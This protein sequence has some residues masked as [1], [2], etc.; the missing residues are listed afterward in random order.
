MITA[1]ERT[2]IEPRLTHSELPSTQSGTGRRDVWFV[3]IVSLTLLVFSSIPFVA[4]YLLARPDRQFM[5]LVYNVHDYAQYMSWARESRDG[6]LVENKLTSEPGPA[7]FFNLYWWSLGRATRLFGLTFIQADQ[8]FRV[9][10]GVAFVLVTWWFCGLAIADRTGRRVAFVLACFASGFGWLLVAL[11]PFVGELRAPLLVHNSLGNTFFSLM[12]TPH[13]I[14]A[15]ANVAASLGLVLQGYRRGCGRRMALA[16]LLALVLGLYHTYDL[17]LVYAVVGAFGS[18]MLLRDGLRPRRLLG[19]VAFYLISAPAPLFWVWLTVAHPEWR[20]V[21]DQFRNLGVFTPDPLGLLVLIGPTLALALV[22]Y[23]G[24]VPL[25]QR[26]DDELLLAAWLGVTLLVIYLPVNFQIMMLNGLQICLAIL[27][28]RALIDHV[29]PWVEQAPQLFGLRI[30]ERVSRARCSVRAIALTLLVLAVLPTNI[31]LLTW[32]ILDL[33]RNEYPYYLRRSDVSALEWLQQHASAT[34]VVLSS[35]E[36]GHFVAGSTGAHAFLA[37]GANTLN[38][39]EK[40]TL[41]ARF[42]G[43]GM[44][45][46]ERS[47]LLERHGVT[48][49]IQGPAEMRGRDGTDMARLLGSPEYIDGETRIWRVGQPGR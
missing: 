9:I 41:V 16:G 31:Y 30:P 5:G 13:H 40:R 23:R 14:L 18:L 36:V 33:N 34:D 44:S 19:F 43:D 17:V 8:A 39:F 47:R 2:S 46:T 21:L 49:V 12:F 7:S 25:R 27:A 35:L 22:T 20:A 42:Y 29:V 15:A 32:R 26:R 48:F 3:T 38:F 10:A 24:V 4:G 6:F 45:D 37:H 1:G 28:T 11:K